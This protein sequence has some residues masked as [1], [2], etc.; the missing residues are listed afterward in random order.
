MLCRGEPPC[1]GFVTG[2]S[3]LGE[4]ARATNQDQEG[5][6]LSLTSRR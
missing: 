2:F 6:G 4:E 1:Y 3:E 5:S